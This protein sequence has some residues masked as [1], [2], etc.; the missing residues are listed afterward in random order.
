MFSYISPGAQNTKQAGYYGTHTPAAQTEAVEDSRVVDDT[1]VTVS[2]PR[3]IVSVSLT[4]RRRC[5]FS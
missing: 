1:T 5:I 4:K 2:D 3:C